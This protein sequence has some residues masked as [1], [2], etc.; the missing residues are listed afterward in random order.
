MQRYKLLSIQRSISLDKCGSGWSEDIPR[1]NLG[2]PQKLYDLL[3]SEDV[4]NA[5]EIKDNDLQHVLNIFVRTNSGG[6]PLTKGDLLLSI[7]TVN[8]AQGNQENARDYVQGII[9]D[10]ASYGYK[11]EKD[12]VLSCILYILGKDNKLSVTNFDKATSEAIYKEK[13]AISSSIKAACA[14]LNRYHIQERGL[15]SKLALL[16]LVYHIYTFKLAQQVSQEY[17]KGQ[18]QPVESGICLDM[19][20]WLFQAIL[21]NFFTAGTNEKLGKI[22][23][24]QQNKSRQDYFPIAEIIE[25]VGLNV[26]DDLIDE[27][28]KTE[29]KNAFP[30]LNVIYSS[31]KGGDYLTKQTEYD[32]DHVHAKT[33]FDKNSDDNRYDTVANLQLLTPPENRSKNAM[34]LKEW[35]DGKSD[36]EK[37]HYLL[38]K[39][40]DANF[41]VFNNFFDKRG[42]WLRAI[43]AEKLDAKVSKYAGVYYEEKVLAAV[44]REGYEKYHLTWNM[45]DDK[46][47][48]MTMTNGDQIYISPRHDLAWP[49]LELTSLT[50]E[51]HSALEA[52]KLARESSVETTD[53]RDNNL[54]CTIAFGIVFDNNQKELDTDVK[55]VFDVFDI[56][57]K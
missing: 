29:K 13:D 8:W 47:M 45:H 51:Q 2:A 7:I 37:E 42:R 36:G 25:A 9:S 20:T 50:E 24:I 28:M 40:F 34:S 32:I 48:R 18:K 6:K 49:M 46:Q 55:K 39:T 35:W 12:W 27:L 38:P 15:T 19:R 57:I 4:L 14:L 33:N 10:V 11:V 43:L 52:A 53:K 41:S 22:Q 17:V 21:T 1:K 31:A 44:F 30:V 56:L 16:P 3:K 54:V 26:N 5:Y 23:K